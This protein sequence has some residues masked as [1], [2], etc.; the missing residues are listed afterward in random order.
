MRAASLTRLVMAAVACSALALPASAA[1]QSARDRNKGWQNDRGWE[2]RAGGEAYQRGFR[3][4]ERLGQ[5]DERRNRAFNVQGHREYREADEGYDRNDGSRDRYR[6]EYR[7]GF[8]E[9]YRVAYRDDRW[10]GNERRATDRWGTTGTWN[11]GGYRDPGQA[12]GFSDG[13]RKGVEDRRDNHRFE[14]ERFKEVK[15][16]TAPGYDDDFGSRDRYTSNY[17]S[18]FRLGYDDGFR[19]A[20]ASR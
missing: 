20:S 10:N 1:A 2:N 18:G 13:Y 3:D 4:G 8:T 15:Q 19:S 7:R 17:R 14:P 9:G 12:R 5:D 16:G 6:D 11:R